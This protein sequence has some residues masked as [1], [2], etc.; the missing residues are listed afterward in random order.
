MATLLHVE[1]LRVQYPADG[2]P[3]RAVD[4]VSFRLERGETYALVGE[5]GC[6][7]SAT[8]LSLLR[9]VEPGRIVDGR[10]MFEG[11]D[12]TLLSEKE[13]RRVRGARIGMV[14]QE[15]SAALDPVMRIGSQVSE[16]LRVH[17]KLSRRQARAEAVRLLR[18]VALPDPER[19]ARAYPHEL[20]GGM[21]QRV[22]LA[23]ALSCAP[24]LVIAD[25][26][27]TALDVTIQAQILALLRGLRREFDLTVLLITH[28]L[29]VV[30]EN[31][32]RVGVMYAGKIVEEA[33]VADLFRDPRHPYT[34]G[35][36]R[37]TPGSED[38]SPGEG[39]G[40]P[41]RL[42]TLPGAVP[43]PAR[44]PSGCRFHP[45]CAERF[46]PCAAAEPAETDLGDGRRVSCFLHAVPDGSPE[47]PVSP[48]VRGVT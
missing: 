23:I 32:D 38:S 35:L 33:A 8:A 42:R 18:V 15:A 5:S 34:R 11:R 20:S 10:M 27:T 45:R 22:M 4:G 24:A 46:D 6:G 9:L 17:R 36:L 2:A 39:P 7:K 44:P 12:L 16:A 1:N 19:Q 48:G 37:A 41:R 13:M 43:D 21:K 47:G 26:P 3:V 29:G 30:A 14:F 40:R 25:E 31:A 28:D